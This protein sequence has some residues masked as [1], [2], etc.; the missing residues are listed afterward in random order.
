MRCG[1]YQFGL[2][3]FSC[4]TLLASYYPDS[5]TVSQMGGIGGEPGPTLKLCFC[6][7]AISGHFL[8]LFGD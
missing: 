5:Q 8:M 3:I 4:A 6:S 7:V 1:K 2:C